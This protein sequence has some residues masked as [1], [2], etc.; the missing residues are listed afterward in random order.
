M[1]KEQAPLA[2][3]IFHFCRRSSDWKHD[4]VQ[5]CNTIASKTGFQ[6]DFEHNH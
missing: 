4:F 1:G 5:H 3:Y 6:L 2:M